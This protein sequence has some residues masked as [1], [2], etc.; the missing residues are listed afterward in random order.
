ML[1][2]LIIHQKITAFANKYLAYDTLPSGETGQVVAFAQQKRFAFKEKVTI[3]NNEQKDAVAFTFRAEKVFDVHGRYLVEDTAGQLIG[4][5]RKEFKKSLL[6]SSWIMMDP[7]GRD[8]L[9]VKESNTTLAVLR[10]FIGFV[11]FLGDI[12]EILIKFFKYHFMFVDITS[13][14]VV[15][16]YRKTTLFRD[17]Y[18]ISLTDDAWARLDKRVFVAMG[19]AL[20]ALQSR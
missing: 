12:L 20:D 5:F 3:Y 17:R 18:T 15:G 14:Q 2:R 6:V 4:M 8:V 10:R 13:G 9:M 1:P 19:V 16:E 11:P 7:E